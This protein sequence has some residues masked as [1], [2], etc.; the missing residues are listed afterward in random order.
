MKV[1]LQT[2]FAVLASTSLLGMLCCV[3]L[4]EP[5]QLPLELSIY[6]ES[7]FG[8]FIGKRTGYTQQMFKSGAS[9]IASRPPEGPCSL[10]VISILFGSL[11]KCTYRAGLRSV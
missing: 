2:V 10:T 4:A 6:T 8:R 11:A 9:P 3:F 1:G 7:L 5:R